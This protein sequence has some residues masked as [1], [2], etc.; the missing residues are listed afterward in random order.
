VADAVIEALW[1]I[2]VDPHRG[3]SISLRPPIF[4][5]N[6]INGFNSKTHNRVESQLFF[7]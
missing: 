5:P 1:L 7:R 3:G 2:E 4:I 6:K